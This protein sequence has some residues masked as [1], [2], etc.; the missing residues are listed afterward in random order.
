MKFKNRIAYLN[1]CCL[2]TLND[3]SRASDDVGLRSVLTFYRQQFSLS[4]KH[5]IRHIYYVFYIQNLPPLNEVNN[6]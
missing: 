2:N 6:N 1:I 5:A 4:D 3:G